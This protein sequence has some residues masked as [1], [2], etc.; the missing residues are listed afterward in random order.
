[1]M[2]S[3]IDSVGSNMGAEEMWDAEQLFMESIGEQPRARETG[4]SADAVPPIM[5]GAGGDETLFV[6]KQTGSLGLPLV[7][8]PA[9]NYPPSASCIWHAV[10]AGEG[11]TSIAAAANTTIGHVTEGGMP[12]PAELY[13]G[14]EVLIC[15]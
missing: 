14:D 5:G 4:L 7:G 8:C 11:C 3:T 12:C 9:P 15:P 13:V 2:L 1:M 6:F 10:A